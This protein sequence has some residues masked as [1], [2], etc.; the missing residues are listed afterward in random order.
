V[1]HE[2]KTASMAIGAARAWDP[3]GTPCPTVLTDDVLEASRPGRAARRFVE[4]GSAGHALGLLRVHS[5]PRSV[6]PRDRARSCRTSGCSAGRSPTRS[7]HSPVCARGPSTDSS[8]RPTLRTVSIIPG[9]ENFAPERT[10]TSSGSS[11]SPSRRPALAPSRAARGGRRPPRPA[12]PAWLAVAAVGRHGTPRSSMVKPGR[13]RE[14]ERWSS[15]RGWLPC[16]QQILGVLV[17]VFEV[18]HEW[19][20]GVPP[21]CG[22]VPVSKL[23]PSSQSVTSE[24]RPTQR[25]APSG[26]RCG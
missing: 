4:V 8:L 5:R 15:R 21:G 11:A 6:H 16:P 25:R 22:F 10:D 23:D 20:H 13:H 19:R 1:F 12:I 18:V 2:L 17:A 26:H 7:A 14:P 3:A 9:I 24:V